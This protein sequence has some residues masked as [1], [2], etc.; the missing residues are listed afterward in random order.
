MP[1][2]KQ[3]TTQQRGL[4][5]ARAR[6]HAHIAPGLRARIGR[7][8]CMDAAH[9]VCGETQRPMGRYG[10]TAIRRAGISHAAAQISAC[11]AALG[12]GCGSYSIPRS[13]YSKA[14]RVV[15]LAPAP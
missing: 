4:R 14:A 12:E 1:C 2:S 6:A 5:V 8:E 9:P 3:H 13:G 15:K 11:M 7:T 10:D